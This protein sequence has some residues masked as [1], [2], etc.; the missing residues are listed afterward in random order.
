MAVEWGV[1]DKVIEKRPEAPAA[2]TVSGR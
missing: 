2:P 1:V